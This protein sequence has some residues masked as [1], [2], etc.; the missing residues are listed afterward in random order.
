MLCFPTGIGL[1]Y[2]KK[3]SNGWIKIHRKIQDHWIWKN[4]IYLKAWISILL[5]VNHKDNNVPVHGELIECKR[6]QSVM[7]LKSWAKFFG[8]KWTVQ[9][10]RTFFKLLENDT[11]INTEGLRKTTRITVCNYDN[12]QKAKH[13]NNTQTTHK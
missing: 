9:K 11:M 7:S 10:V 6:G 5:N 3:M 13:T 1:F 4:E 12:Y 8:P 2:F